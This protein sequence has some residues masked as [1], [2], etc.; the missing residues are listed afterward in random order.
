MSPS[1]RNPDSKR[2]ELLEDALPPARRSIDSATAAVLQTLVEA[3]A[4]DPHAPSSVRD[5]EEAWRVHIADSLSG[6]VFDQLADAATIADLGSGAGFPGL[7]LAAAL[8]DAQLDL[9]ESN[10]R[11]CEYLERVILSAGVPNA[12]PV[13]VRS[14][15]LAAGRGREA[16]DAVC[17]R[18]VGRLATL[19]EL[20]SPLLRP[21]GVLVAWK[22]KRDTD[23]EAELE[24]A[25]EALAMEP[26]DIV[27]VG[28]YAGSRHRHLHLVRKS[29]PTPANLP[30]RPGMAKKRPFGAT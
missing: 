21:G 20:S 17:A 3:L 1:A 26:C 12:R 6:L 23:E 10:G 30:R 8:R 7:P 16:Y 27:A 24:G 25:A 29:G 11:K 28:P 2:L 15:T 13:S 19:A 9:V 18:A 22:G 14:E 4:S 5:R